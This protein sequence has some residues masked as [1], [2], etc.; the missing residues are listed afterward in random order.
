MVYIK[1]EYKNKCKKVH[2]PDD[3]MT[4]EMVQDKMAQAFDL[5]SSFQDDQKLYQQPQFSGQKSKIK[6]FSL[7]LSEGDEED[8][9]KLENSAEIV[10][11]ESE[12]LMNVF[13][14]GIEDLLQEINGTMKNMLEKMNQKDKNGKQEDYQYKMELDIQQLTTVLQERMFQ[15]LQNMSI[16]KHSQSQIKL[17]EQ[18]IKKKYLE[19]LEQ[20]NKQTIKIK[21][22]S[23]EQTPQPKNNLDS[24][25]SQ[26]KNSKLLDNLVDKQEDDKKDE[27]VNQQDNQNQNQQQ[28]FEKQVQNLNDEVDNK[29]DLQEQKEEQYEFIGQTKSN[30]EKEEIHNINEQIIEKFKKDHLKE[31][32][33]KEQELSQRLEEIEK[34]VRYENSNQNTFNQSTRLIE[35]SMKLFGLNN[36][37]KNTVNQK[38][39]QQKNI[40]SETDEIMNFI[41]EQSSEQLKQI[42]RF[43]NQ[44]IVITVN[45]VNNSRVNQQQDKKYNE[46]ENLEKMNDINNNGNDQCNKNSGSNLLKVDQQKSDEVISISSQLKISKLS[47]NNKYSS[48]HDEDIENLSLDGDFDQE[49]QDIYP[50]SESDIENQQNDLQFDDNGKLSENNKKITLRD[51][52]NIINQKYPQDES[53]NQKQDDDDDD[54][55]F[56]NQIEVKMSKRISTK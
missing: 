37:G 27:S 48:Y 29:S 14:R 45:Q 36:L 13:A 24:K 42:E 9:N 19:P 8:K 31:I 3:N 4:F 12:D 44:N 53:R 54:K 46:D 28:N 20:L 5:S 51:Q 34:S 6:K 32:E 30:N 25:F 15:E 35:Q 7:V 40:I 55:E 10:D 33:Q 52:Q 39:K 26:F 22:S 17:N 18:Q 11:L 16:S 41:N 2:I 49:N 23:S 43:D 1:L 21:N 50:N 47:Q 38:K 56:F